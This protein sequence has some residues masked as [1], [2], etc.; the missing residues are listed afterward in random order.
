MTT[1]TKNICKDSPYFI[2]IRIAVLLLMTPVKANLQ[3]HL[4]ISIIFTL[5][6]NRLVYKT[7]KPKMLYPTKVCDNRAN[8]F[9][10]IE[11]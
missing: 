8:I 11:S 5:R 7:T 4:Y 10:G 6:I 3:Y 1:S 2:G 9:C